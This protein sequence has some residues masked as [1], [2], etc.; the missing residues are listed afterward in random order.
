MPGDPMKVTIKKK[1]FS[2]P[3]VIITFHT[4]AS[5]FESDY[6][7]NKFF[8]GLYGWKQIVPVKKKKYRYHREGL[9]DEVPHMKIAD[10]VLLVALK[11]LE[12]M[13]EYF[14][15]WEDKVDFDIMEV[16]LNKKIKNILEEKRE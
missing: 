15:E 7:R 14:E 2:S 3:A 5:K 1:S 13:R 4:R 6:E 10:S 12:R 11:H 16:M 9:L 8:R